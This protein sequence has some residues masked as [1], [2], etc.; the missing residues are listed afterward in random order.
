[1]NIRDKDFFKWFIA[2]GFGLGYTPWIPGTAAAFIGVIFHVLLI[3]FTPV[4]VQHLGILGLF[5]IVCFGNQLL[6]NWAVEY[7]DN[8]DPSHFV[9]DEIAGYLFTILVFLVIEDLKFPNPTYDCWRMIG[10]NFVLFRIFDSIKIPPAN[11]I[12]KNLHGS[13]GIILD[14]LV[15]GFYAAVVATLI[16]HYY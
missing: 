12:D 9:L 16:I 3:W 8:E 2:S 6:T 7:W 4:Y 1:M 13:L 5:I 10:V 15:S 11:F 14:D